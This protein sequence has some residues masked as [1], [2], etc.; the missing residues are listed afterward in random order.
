MTNLSIK[1]IS[2][3]VKRRLLNLAREQK[4]PFQEFLQYYAMERFLFRLSESSYKDRFILKGALLFKV[5]EIT[6]SRTTLDIDVLAKTSNSLDHVISIVQHL[7]MFTPSVDDGIQFLADSIHGQVMQ[8]QREY[9]GVRIRFQGSMDSARIPMQID[10]GFGDIVTPSPDEI[11]YPTLLDF[12]PPTLKAY[13]PQTVIAE[14]I[15]TMVE[16][17]DSNSRIKDYYDVWLLIRRPGTTFPNLR[18][19]FLRT[20]KAREMEFDLD[21][22]RTTIE[23]YTSLPQTKLLW[24]R[25]KQKELPHLHA[26][27]GFQ[28]LTQDILD[29][30]FKEL[31]Q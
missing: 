19:A 3:S 10:I 31:L 30:L 29:F 1:N 15:H 24:E 17:G 11:T 20:F 9:E 13:P 26:N 6:H 7:C 28:D 27:F 12:P 18:R 8:L 16:K 25:F 21:L 14:K 2:A 22:I 5:W 23:H 4:R